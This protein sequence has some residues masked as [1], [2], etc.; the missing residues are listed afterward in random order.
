VQID[1]SVERAE[2]AAAAANARLYA[3]QLKRA[4][5]LKR[6][7]FASQ[8][9]Y[10]TV[11]AQLEV[12]RSTQKRQQAIID[13]KSI[14]APFDGTLGIARIDVG[15]YLTAGTIAVTLQDLDRI[16]V[17]FTVPETT[18]VALALGQT[19]RIGG[20]KSDLRFKWRIIGID[21]KVDPD[22]RLV[23]V[24]AEIAEAN[25]RI[26][27]GQFLRLR[28][29]LPGESSVIALPQTAIVPSLYGDYVFVVAPPEPAPATAATNGMPQGPPPALVAKQRFI[30]TGRR[31]GVRVEI[32]RG[33]KPGERVVTT[34]QNRLQDG[35]PVAIAEP[36]ARA[37][38]A[39]GAESRQ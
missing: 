30:T 8:A 22:S 35:A 3:A 6:K 14:E 23:A 15:Q 27:P 29:E 17:D 34:G 32:I 13:Q 19:V 24:Q 38:A 5:A 21:P 2:L 28:V 7:G 11:L 33:L 16:K 31:D 26:K 4:E 37:P 1:D 20:D 10:D 9:A 25:G 36:P 12:A 39:A 18:A